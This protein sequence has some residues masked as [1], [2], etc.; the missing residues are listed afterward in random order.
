MK[1]DAK[2]NI[3]IGMSNSCPTSRA[4][5]SRTSKTQYASHGSISEAPSY[6]GR[7]TS[8]ISP[9]QNGEIAEDE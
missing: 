8:A 2:K 9:F 4:S 7:S 6:Q 1:P 5:L 3:L